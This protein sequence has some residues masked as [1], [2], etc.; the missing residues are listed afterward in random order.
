MPTVSERLEAAIQISL[1]KR[2]MNDRE[3]LQAVIQGNENH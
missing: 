2:R 1:R 3:R